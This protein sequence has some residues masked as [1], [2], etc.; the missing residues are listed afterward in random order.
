MDILVDGGI[1]R[2]TDVLKCLAMG[3]NAVLV[4]RPIL[5]GLAVNGSSGV[6][7]VISLLANE[8]TVNMRL[9]GYDSVSSLMENGY[10]ILAPKT[11]T[12]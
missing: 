1:R 12:L 5:W 9:C 4:G 2:G 8:M 10:H 3:A 6:K 11:I 7:H